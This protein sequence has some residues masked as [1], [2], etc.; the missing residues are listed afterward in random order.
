MTSDPR[1]G[2]VEEDPPAVVGE[3]M[4]VGL[5]D[6]VGRLDDGR[7]EVLLDCIAPG[8]SG[9]DSVDPGRGE[10]GPSSAATKSSSLRTVK[11]DS[12]RLIPPCELGE[13]ALS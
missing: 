7:A 12:E 3:L 4:F 10:A 11:P 8:E 6:E 9:F 1:F 2:L 13:V 5:L